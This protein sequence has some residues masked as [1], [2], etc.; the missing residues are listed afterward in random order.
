MVCYLDVSVKV[1]VKKMIELESCVLNPF[2][3]LEERG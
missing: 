2:D 1:I 3:V